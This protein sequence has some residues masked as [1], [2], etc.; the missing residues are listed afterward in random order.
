MKNSFFV[1][2]DFE[3]PMKMKTRSFLNEDE[4][5]GAFSF[6]ASCRIVCAFITS[7]PIFPMVVMG[8]TSG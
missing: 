3:L 8:P 6:R 4:I 7:G 2:S 1:K 5:S